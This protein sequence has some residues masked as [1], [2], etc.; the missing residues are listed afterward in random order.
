LKCPGRNISDKK[1]QKKVEDLKLQRLFHVAKVAYEDQ[2]IERLDRLELMWENYVLEK[3]PINKVK[4]LSSIFTI[5][6]YISS[7][8]EATIYLVGNK[9][10]KIKGEMEFQKHIQPKP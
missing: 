9:E 5:Q 4:I 8:Y 2:H 1:R 7:Y 6:P 10:A 3:T